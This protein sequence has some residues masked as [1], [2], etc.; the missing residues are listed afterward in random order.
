[1]T[2]EEV[3]VMASPVAK[4]LFEFLDLFARDALYHG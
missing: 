1:M 2:S 4:N 3:H